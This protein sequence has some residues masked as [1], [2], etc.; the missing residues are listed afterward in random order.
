MCQVITDYYLYNTVYWIQTEVEDIIDRIC[1]Y[2][3][4]RIDDELS[5]MLS[6]RTQQ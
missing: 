1:N 4:L 6:C 2:I 5:Y 3:L